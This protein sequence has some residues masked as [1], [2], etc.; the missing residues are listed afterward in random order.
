M[1]KIDKYKILTEKWVLIKG[2]IWIPDNNNSHTEKLYSM[3]LIIDQTQQK[4]GLV[5]LSPDQWKSAPMR[6]IM[7][8][9]KDCLETCR[10]ISNI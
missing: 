1:N 10:A 5:K 7:K 2:K 8:T 9:E 6:K 3:F 4:E